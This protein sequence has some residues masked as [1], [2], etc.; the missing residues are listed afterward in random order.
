MSSRARSRTQSTRAGWLPRSTTPSRGRSSSS[1]TAMEIRA[2][3]SRQLTVLDP[4][5]RELVQSVGAALF[6]V[7]AALAARG[8]ATAVER[9]PR[10][11]DPDLLAVVRPVDGEPDPVL[12]GL[13]RAIPRRHTNRRPF[14]PVTVPDEIVD[15]LTEATAAEAARLIALRSP[16][17]LGLV[18]EL[19]QQADRL[20]SADPGY[21]DELRQWTSRTPAQGDG[22]TAGS[23]P[24]TT[25]VRTDAVP[26]RDFDTR[27]TGGL[28][29]R[30]GSGTDQTLVLLAT[31][32]DDPVAW[33]RSG[34][35]LERLLLEL[36]RR[37]WAGRADHPGPGGPG[38]AHPPARAHRAWTPAD[39]AADR[40]GSGGGRRSPTA[41]P[42]RGRGQQSARRRRSNGRPRRVAGPPSRMIPDRSRTAEEGRPGCDDERVGRSHRPSAD[43]RAD[44]GTPFSC[45][46][47]PRRGQTWLP[48]RPTRSTAAR[49]CGQRSSP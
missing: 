48:G 11:A 47:R 44:S 38:D 13:A 21:R 6:N 8:F 14:T 17:Q 2:D 3:R 19:T 34:E 15:H 16:D 36:T 5:G 39:A 49:P 1:P 23:V 43:G 4:A 7:R 18:A 28:P 25:G 35:A 27:G 33:L 40:P 24:R 26:L 31:A 9:L 12:A 45:R 20:Q 10:P 22:V 32:Q 37:D 42:D 29:A 30:T 46:S 41:A